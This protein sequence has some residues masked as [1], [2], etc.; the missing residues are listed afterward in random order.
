MKD[1]TGVNIE[2]FRGMDMAGAERYWCVEISISAGGGK[3]AKSH[4]QSI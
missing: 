4:V 3:Y 2:A 1:S